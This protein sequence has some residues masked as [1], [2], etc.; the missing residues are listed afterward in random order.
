MSATVAES[1]TAVKL[2]AVTESMTESES[3]RAVMSTTV[4]D[5]VTAAKPWTVA[6]S[7]TVVES[8]TAVATAAESVTTTTE[9]LSTQQSYYQ[10]GEA[11]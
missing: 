11:M 7:V 10:Y 1:V 6:E 4:T 8:A 5:S 3:T 9:I 2:G